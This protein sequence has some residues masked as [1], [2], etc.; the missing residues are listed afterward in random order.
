MSQ[1]FATHGTANA[2]PSAATR[3]QPRDSPD[4]SALS[5]R[6]PNQQQRTRDQFGDRAE[7]RNSQPRLLIFGRRRNPDVTASE[8][9]S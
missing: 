6:D 4:A 8:W 5:H 3:D 9:A 1:R 2:G 7:A